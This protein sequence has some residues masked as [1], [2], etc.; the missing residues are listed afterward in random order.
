MI[1][2]RHCTLTVH[3]V[4][5]PLEY[6]RWVTGDNV[7]ADSYKASKDG[8][9]IIH[10]ESKGYD[11]SEQDGRREALKNILTLLWAIQ[12]PGTSTLGIHVARVLAKKVP[13][14]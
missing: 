12:F 6:L 3:T 2:M 13:A 11:L 9:A 14:L 1:Q 8:Y 4:R 7:N 5:F 10:K